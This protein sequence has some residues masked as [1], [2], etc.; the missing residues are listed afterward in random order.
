MPKTETSSPHEMSSFRRNEEK[1]SV[2]PQKDP[3]K[4]WKTRQEQAAQG[5]AP[6]DPTTREIP[7]HQMP[8]PQ[9]FSHQ[10]NP[11]I[12]S[13]DVTVWD[14]AGEIV[15]GRDGL[16]VMK[17]EIVLAGDGDLLSASD[18]HVVLINELHVG[19]D[20]TLL[21]PDKL[22]VKGMRRKNVVT[23]DGLLLD[24]NGLPVLSTQGC[25]VKETDM[26]FLGHHDL[27]RQDVIVQRDG[28]LHTPDGEEILGEDGLV[29]TRGEV[30]MGDDDKPVL[31][32]EGK[33]IMQHDMKFSNSDVL[34]S[35]GGEVIRG[36]SGEPLLR[37]NVYVG[38]EGHPRLSRDGKII[39]MSDV[40]HNFNNEPL[41]GSKFKEPI[42]SKDLKFSKKGVLIG[43]GTVI[44]NKDGTPYK[45][46]QVLV[47]DDGKPLLT[48]DRHPV[49]AMDVTFSLSGCAVVSGTAH[50]LAK[51]GK[52]LAQKD[53]L[54]DAD[55]CPKLTVE[56]RLMKLEDFVH[57]FDGSM[58]TDSNH[59]PVSCTDLTFSPDGKLTTNRGMVVLDHNALP[60]N[61]DDIVI[62]VDGKPVFSS[63]GQLI[64]KN[65]M[66]VVSS[67]ET[68]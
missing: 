67:S 27:P 14:D 6:G 51:D 61:R 28:T 21:G 11:A 8:T 56:G 32:P 23:T 12:F 50:I 9:Y 52:P 20:G 58:L 31:T 54:L 53:L 57:G 2:W 44:C 18:G 39:Q 10:R 4:S 40:V 45:R 64:R 62:S 48:K 30:L 66:K 47:G 3:Q 36:Q 13:E 5:K 7:G 17:G 41:F 68:E 42:T 46:G 26:M 43:L 38:D 24:L 16:P 15:L 37:E 34:Y 63:T 49:T 29:L 33:P 22:P 1:E 25:L 60:V 19:K 35:P 65:D 55:G 59:N